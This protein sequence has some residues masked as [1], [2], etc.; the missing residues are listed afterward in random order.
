M[1]L[2]GHLDFDLTLTEILCVYSYIVIETW[3]KFYIS[4]F[5]VGP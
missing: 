4:W 1:A 3:T 2:D 5:I